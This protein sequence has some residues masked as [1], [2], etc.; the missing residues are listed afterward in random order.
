[1]DTSLYISNTKMQFV[2]GE[3]KKGGISVSAFKTVELLEET[4]INGL[5][6][7]EGRFDEAF[8][9]II[10]AHPAR[11]GMKKVRLTI[12]SGQALVK[13]RKIPKMSESKI[14]QWMKGEFSEAESEDEEYLYDY[15][16]MDI[17]KDGDIAL[18]CAI[19]KSMLDNYVNIFEDADISLSC[20]DIGLNSQA[21]LIHKM[22]A[23]EGKT[24]LVLTIDGNMMDTVLY[25]NGLYAVSNRNRILTERGSSDLGEEVSR[26]V[27]GMIQFN[28]SQKNEQSIESI[29]MCG[30]RP[31]EDA[32]KEY[33]SGAYSLVLRNLKEDADIIEVYDQDFYPD[34]YLYAVG[35][36]IRE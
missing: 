22:P 7:N 13:A 8:Q 27:S 30:F 23:T 3:E 10:E 11:G 1:M 28:H 2:C 19:K 34:K 5:I 33:V 21:K 24:F 26:I 6:V 20:I 15:E 14:L 32:V 31:D 17:K 25:I 4:V 35:N 9:K 12:G 29:Y 16:I 18:L 36:L